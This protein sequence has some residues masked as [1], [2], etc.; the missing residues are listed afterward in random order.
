M[1]KKIDPE[2]DDNDNVP[3]LFNEC[4][5]KHY[6]NACIKAIEK[7]NFSIILKECNF[8]HVSAQPV[9]R[10]ETGILIMDTEIKLTIQELNPIDN[11]LQAFLP[12]KFPV[13]IVS[14]KNLNI[15]FNDKHIV[16][17]PI[18]TNAVTSIVYTY[19]SDE[20]ILS[21]IKSADLID[22]ISDIEYIEYIDL[23]FLLLFIVLVP[24]ILTLCCIGIKRSEIWVK[25]KESKAQKIYNRTRKISKN[26]SENK[27]MMKEMRQK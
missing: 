24:I 18:Q 3:D 5:Y 26:F 20:F 11:R 15:Q 25:C 12:N 1:K 9:W 27:R 13:H 4:N 17:T 22:F 21:M 16:Y 7:D 6:E 23:I 19:L 8:T 2:Y 14:N 10:T